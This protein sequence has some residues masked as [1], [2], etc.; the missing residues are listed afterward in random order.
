MS[1]KIALLKSNEEVIC[2]MKEVITEDNKLAAY[3]F[4][5]PYTVK[6]DGRD[7]EKEEES[8]E[9]SKL[10]KLSFTPWVLLSNDREFLINPD[11]IVTIYNPEPGIEQSY[12]EKIYE[13]LGDDRYDGG[14]GGGDA[15]G[16]ESPDQTDPS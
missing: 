14:D 2:E 13:R 4:K 9:E 3:S 6:I 16:T 12:K 10:Y 1:I 5:Y 11:W 15:N 8:E 7:Y